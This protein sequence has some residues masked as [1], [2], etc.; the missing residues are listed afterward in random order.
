MST[1]AAAQQSAFRPDRDTLVG[2]HQRHAA[3]GLDAEPVQIRDS[4][5]E[6]PDGKSGACLPSRANDSADQ[7]ARNLAE[8]RSVEGLQAMDVEGHCRRVSAEAPTLNERRQVRNASQRGLRRTKARR[9]KD[10]RRRMDYTGARGV[11]ATRSTSAKPLGGRAGT[12]TE[13]GGMTISVQ[14]FPCL[15]DN[16]GALVHDPATGATA[17]VDAPE[18]GPILAAL[19]AR[20]WNLTDVL[21]T[22]HHADHIQ[23]V[24][25]AEGEVS[26]A[27][28]PWTGQGGGA[29]SVSRR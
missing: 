4:I 29:H 26:G 16:Y 7:P 6:R 15:T 27:Q 3:F 23:G 25:G 28:G 12:A 13:P 22:H 21:I 1:K 5:T 10:A 8:R 9:A 24:P 11:S 19:A 14:Q 2:G 18:A 17:C 20:A